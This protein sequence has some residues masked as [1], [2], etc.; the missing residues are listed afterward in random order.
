MKSRC[1]ITLGERW[2][3][4][5]SISSSIAV[6]PNVVMISI[7]I[8]VAPKLV[9]IAVGPNLFISFN[10]H[11]LLYLFVLGVPLCVS[12]ERVLLFVYLL[13]LMVFPVPFVFSIYIYIYIYGN[14]LQQ[15]AACSSESH[16]MLSSGCE[17]PG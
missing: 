10:F 1:R 13:C 12:H 11:C 5:M 16:K 9:M 4:M 6:G 3:V 7:S 8:A 15:I 2:L 17:A 14:K